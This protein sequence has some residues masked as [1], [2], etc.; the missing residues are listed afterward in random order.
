M[1]VGL[2]SLLRTVPLL[3]STTDRGAYNSAVVWDVDGTLVESTDWLG[4]LAKLRVS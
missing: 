4:S 1:R 2:A 3:M